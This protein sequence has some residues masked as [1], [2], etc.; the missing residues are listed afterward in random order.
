[1][2]VARPALLAIA[3]A[4]LCGGP[5]LADGRFRNLMPYS[6][7]RGMLQRLGYRPYLMPGSDV[8][9]PNEP[10]CFPE[11]EFCVA[12]R[13]AGCTYTWRR[14]RSI[15]EV[16]T[17]YVDPVVVRSECVV[18]CGKRNEQPKAVR[19]SLPVHASLD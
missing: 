17:Q 6:E 3:L 14:G 11:L 19:A 7:A 4:V 12:N 5:A 1:M 10:R 15:I 18:N 13:L 8:C 16:G 9:D 2:A